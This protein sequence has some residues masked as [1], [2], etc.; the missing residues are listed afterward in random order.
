MYANKKCFVKHAKSCVLRTL[1]FARKTDGQTIDIEI[2]TDAVTLPLR[3]MHA[4][5]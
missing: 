2:T 5:R 1:T 3:R 4:H